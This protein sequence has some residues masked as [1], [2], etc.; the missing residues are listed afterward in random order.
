LGLDV[1]SNYRNGLSEFAEVADV[2]A[3]ANSD[4]TN[5]MQVLELLDYA[6]TSSLTRS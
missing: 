2:S 5:S 1:D 4:T 3:K 6:S